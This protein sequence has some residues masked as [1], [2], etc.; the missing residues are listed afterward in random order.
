MISNIKKS[1]FLRI[2]LPL[3]TVVAVQMSAAAI[4]CYCNTGDV[5][6]E[7]V[8]CRC[9]STST[10]HGSSHPSS[11][12]PNPESRSGD[13]CQ[14]V[15]F[16]VLATFDATDKPQNCKIVQF[17][18]FS[19]DIETIPRA[20]LLVKARMHRPIVHPQFFTSLDVIILQL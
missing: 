15:P 6:I 14:D 12:L 2:T 8:F 16:S 19:S 5:A 13:S 18:T 1:G 4:R 3:L 11:T 9:C 20:N 7:S 17:P 10:V